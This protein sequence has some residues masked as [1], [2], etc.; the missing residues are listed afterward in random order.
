MSALC[1]W[2]L[3]CALL[4]EPFKISSTHWYYV[5][6]SQN[7]YELFQSACQLQLAQHIRSSRSVGCLCMSS[8]KFTGCKSGLCLCTRLVNF[9]GCLQGAALQLFFIQLFKVR[10][11]NTIS[12]F[13]CTMWTSAFPVRCTGDVLNFAVSETGRSEIWLLVSVV[14]TC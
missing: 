10:Y 6:I 12:H 11:V 7:V 3:W 13:P 2:R 1:L 9:Q 14:C 5:H 4:W 8:H